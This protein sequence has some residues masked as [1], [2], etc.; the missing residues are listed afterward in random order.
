M[1]D[2]YAVQHHGADSPQAVQ[3]VAA[4]LLVLHG[5]LFRG[6]SPSNRLWVL[7]RALRKRRIFH[8]LEPPPVGKALTI[9]HLFP[10][11]SVGS[12]ASPDEYVWSVYEAW[13]EVHSPAIERWYNRYVVPDQI[14]EHHPA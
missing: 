2:A 5:T 14:P 10:G 1:G 11:E 9:R 8:K 6:V 7:G 12:P 3:S 4:H 13:S